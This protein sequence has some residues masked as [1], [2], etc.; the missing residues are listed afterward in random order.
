[1]RKL[2]F[3]P[4]EVIL[5]RK[6]KLGHLLTTG[7]LRSYVRFI[8]SAEWISLPRN[9][10]AQALG[11]ERIPRS[12]AVV[13]RFYLN[14]KL[15]VLNMVPRFL[16][17]GERVCSYRDGWHKSFN[18]TGTD[19]MHVS[20][21]ALRRLLGIGRREGGAYQLKADSKHGILICYLDRPI[22]QA[23]RAEKACD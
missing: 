16:A 15:K 2:A 7:M 9:H 12:E 8:R 6:P 13:F 4:F 23:H 1:M 21:V 10:V 11:V 22:S 3:S 14:P 19:R 18:L 20:V 5:V 17:E